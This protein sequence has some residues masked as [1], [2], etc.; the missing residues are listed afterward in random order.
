M[1]KYDFIK[2]HYFN[3]Y[4]VDFKDTSIRLIGKLKLNYVLFQDYIDKN[5]KKGNISEI[6]MINCCVTDDTNKDVYINKDFFMQFPNLESIILDNNVFE[7]PKFDVPDKV[8]YISLAGNLVKDT[9]N[10]KLNEIVEVNLKHAARIPDYIPNIYNNNILLNRQV[11]IRE[12]PVN[13]VNII[14]EIPVVGNVR[15]VGIIGA[16]VP[17]VHNVHDNPIQENVKKSLCVIFKD[18]NELNKPDDYDENYL[19]DIINL[20][21]K[22]EGNSCFPK[23]G[24]SKFENLLT[25]YNNFNDNV[26]YSYNPYKTCKLSDI[27]ERIHYYMKVLPEDQQFNIV[28]NLSIQLGDGEKMCF[29]G[30]YTRLLNTLS[31][32]VPEVNMDLPISEKMANKITV[33]LKEK[34]KVTNQNLIDKLIEF[35]DSLEMSEEDKEIWND[36]FKDRLEEQP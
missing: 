22:K 30:K 17:V 14:R 11:P 1:I 36:A 20:Y 19:R 5:V 4:T 15:N 2:D 32:F 18:L 28:E 3:K 29:V 12:I 7:D 35:E 33:L 34:G 31:S 13:P 27:I 24:K 8:T 9:N 21:N 26:C 6:T 10:M 25:Y 23:F 16:R